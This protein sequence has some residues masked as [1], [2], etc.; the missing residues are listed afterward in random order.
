MGALA[1]LGV[2]SHIP[3]K[4]FRSSK[5]T[6]KRQQRPKSHAGTVCVEL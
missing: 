1:D 3:G 6:Q 4:G 2:A 5:L